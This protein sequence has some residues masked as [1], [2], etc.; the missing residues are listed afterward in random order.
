MPRVLELDAQHFRRVRAAHDELQR[1]VIPDRHVLGDR[2]LLNVAAQALRVRRQ[3]QDVLAA[4]DHHGPVDQEAF[5]VA[6][7]GGPRLAHFQRGH[8]VGAQA[9]EQ[10][11]ALPTG[12]DE[13][14]AGGPVEKRCLF[15]GGAIIRIALR[16]DRTVR[17]RS[18]SV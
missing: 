13:P 15:H 16:G 9:V 2:V 17:R 12:D 10:I 5:A 18:P 14:A 11:L 4:V 3:D 1:H 7:T 8:I 6:E